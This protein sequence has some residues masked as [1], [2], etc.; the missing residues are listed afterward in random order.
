MG[1]TLNRTEKE[2]Y[3]GEVFPLYGNSN[4]NAVRWM[5]DNNEAVLIKEFPMDRD[6]ARCDT[7]ILAVCLKPGD[8][9][10]TAEHDGNTVSCCIHVR[11]RHISALDAQFNYYFGDFHSHTTMDHKKATFLLRGEEDQPVNSM[12]MV[13]DE[14]F[15]DCFA[16]TDHG[17]IVDDAEFFR[18]FR[19]A[20]ACESSNFIPFPGTESEVD[21]DEYDRFGIKHRNS[22]EVVTFNS[23]GYASVPTWKE[24]Y[25]LV[26]DNPLTISCLA[27]PQIYGFS[28]AGLWNFSLA[29]KTTPDMLRSIHLVELGNGTTREA[30]LVNERV[31]SLA[32]DCGYKIAPAMNSDSH[33]RIWGKNALPGRTVL[34]AEEKSREAFLDAILASRVYATESGDVKLYYTVNGV[35]M[36]STVPETDNYQ[37]KVKLESFGAGIRQKTLEVISDG[38]LVV[39]AQELAENES[40]IVFTVKSD[41]ARWFYLRIFDENGKR[42]WSPAIWTGRAFDPIC[43]D[44]FDRPEYPK[45][46][47]TVT[48][49]GDAEKLINGDPTDTWTA[50]GTETEMLFNLGARVRISALGLYPHTP[51]RS[52]EISQEIQYASFP[53]Q[54]KIE[55]SIDGKNFD[56]V[57]DVYV[58]SF[59]GEQI[60]PMDCTAKY[61]RLKLTAVGVQLRFSEFANAPVKV[62]EISFFI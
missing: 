57:R 52:K 2:A 6:T 14:G 51:V 13:R 47:I 22:G 34:L 29:R 20:E 45:R 36:A 33:G 41:T 16:V 54:C 24:Y 43:S 58:R 62:G 7:G 49:T 11:E 25:K 27:H 39:Y 56:T 9:T 17:D 61:V 55:I 19:Q 12:S 50:D 53:G 26:G 8:V 32:L 21:E 35:P 15:Y 44:L 38:G 31:Y 30:N 60:I 46:E 3:V 23:A 5:S 28:C 18:M 4:G 40:E 42:T 48:A 10:I 59:G 37:F 1:F